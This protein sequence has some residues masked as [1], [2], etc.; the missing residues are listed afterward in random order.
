MMCRWIERIRIHDNRIFHIHIVASLLTVLTPH[1]STS[2]PA[3]RQDADWGWK[4]K[5]NKHD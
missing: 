2:V 3:D 4:N 1:G 5:N